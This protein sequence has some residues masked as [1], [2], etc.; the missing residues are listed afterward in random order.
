MKIK[1]MLTIFYVPY[2]RSFPQ[3]LSHCLLEKSEM[4]INLQMLIQ[5]NT[6]NVLSSCCFLEN[7]CSAM[8]SSVCLAQTP[9]WHMQKPGF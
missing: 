9:F 5:K 2:S 6:F 4:I 1:A 8:S 3:N 7:T